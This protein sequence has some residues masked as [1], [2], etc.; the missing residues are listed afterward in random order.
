[1]RFEYLRSRGIRNIS[2]HR[3]VFRLGYKVHQNPIPTIE[4]PMLAFQA[5][6]LEALNHNYIREFTKI[7]DP[8]IVP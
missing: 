7:G 6:P 1:M 3:I 2:G 8:N 5:L 4:A